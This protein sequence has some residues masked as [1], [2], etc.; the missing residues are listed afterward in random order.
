M[1]TEKANIS[2]AKKGYFCLSFT[3]N[4]QVSI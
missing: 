2:R 4:L 3:Q 1:L